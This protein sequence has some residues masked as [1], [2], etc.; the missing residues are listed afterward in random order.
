MLR[1]LNRITVFL[2]I[3]TTTFLTYT[4]RRNSARSNG[5]YVDDGSGIDSSRSA[6][7]DASRSLFL[8][9]DQCAAAFPGFNKEIENAVAK[10]SVELRRRKDST[11]GLVQGRIKN[12]KVWL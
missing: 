12:G 7:K 5:L 8:T 4:Y 11:P 9:E 3:L 6:S 10:G 1:K 2:L